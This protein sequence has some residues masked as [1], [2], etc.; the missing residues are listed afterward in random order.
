MEKHHLEDYGL[1]TKKFKC[2]LSY[3]EYSDD[4]TLSEPSRAMMKI[5]SADKIKKKYLQKI[6]NYSILYGIKYYYPCTKIY[7][8][9]YLF[10]LYI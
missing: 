1:N 3:F 7:F 8:D 10:N 9:F 5:L 2:N 4:R 6:R